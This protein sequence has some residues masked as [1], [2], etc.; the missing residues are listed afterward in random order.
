MAFELPSHVQKSIG[1]FTGRTWLLPRIRQWLEKTSDRVFLVSGKPGA[2]NSMISAWLSGK[3]PAPNEPA[4]AADLNCIRSTVSAIHFCQATSGNAPRAFAESVAKQLASTVPGFADCVV[5][6]LAERKQVNVNATVNVQRAEHSTITGIELNLQLGSLTDEPAFDGLLHEPLKALYGGGYS[7]PILVIVNALDES[8]IYTGTPKLPHLLTR[9]GEI[10]SQFRILVTTRND[11]EVLKL[12]RSVPPCDRCDL[13]DDA[14]AD[15]ADVLEYARRRLR[16]LIAIGDQARDQFA[17]RLSESA[18]GVFLYAAVVLDELLKA[19]SAKLPD[20]D[21]YP[22]PEGLSTLYHDLLTRKLG[23]DQHQWF[24]VYEPLLGLIAVGQGEG[25]TAR[26]LT[27]IVGKDVRAGL[28]DCKEYLAGKLP[29][30]P[31]RVFRKSFA[32]FLLEDKDNVDFHIDAVSMHR[33]IVE[34]Y[35]SQHPEDWSKCDDYGLSNLALHLRQAGLFDRLGQLISQEWM[36]MRVERRR[37][38]YDGFVADVMLA[39]NDAR[40][41]A[42]ADIEAGKEPRTFAECVWY[43]LIRTS[44]RSLVS[45]YEPELL[46]RAVETGLWSLD[47]AVSVATQVR[48]PRNRMRLLRAALESADAPINDTERRRIVSAALSTVRSIE[49]PEARAIGLCALAPRLSGPEKVAALAEELAAARKIQDIAPRVKALAALAP[50]LSGPEKDKALQDAWKLLL[51]PLKTKETQSAAMWISLPPGIFGL[52]QI[53]RLQAMSTLAP[54]SSGLLPS[55]AMSVAQQIEDSES[56]AMVLAALLPGLNGDTKETALREA[57]SAAKRIEDGWARARTLATLGPQLTS[58]LAIETLP[59]VHAIKDSASRAKALAALAQRVSGPDEKQLVREA[60]SAARQIEDDASQSDVLA[61]LAA[62]LTGPLALEALQV[63]RTIKDT[64]SRANALT[65]LAG[66]L[67][68]AE[69]D[70]CLRTSL[71]AVKQVEN[72]HLRARLMAALAPHLTNSLLAEALSIARASDGGAPRSQT[73]AALVPKLSDADQAVVLRE[74]LDAVRN[75]R[76]WQRIEALSALAPYLSGELLAEALRVQVIEDVQSCASSLTAIARDL[77]GPQKEAVLNNVL[78][79][80]NEADDDWQRAEILVKLASQLSGALLAEA[81]SAARA[82]V[83][84]IPRA[85]ALAA[86]AKQFSDTEKQ[87]MLNE[88]LSSAKNIDQDATRAKFLAALASQLTGDV[89]R[90]TIREAVF[91]ARTA[92]RSAFPKMPE[93]GELVAALAQLDGSLISDALSMVRQMQFGR[94]RAAALAAL[95]QQMT[96]HEREATLADEVNQLSMA[97]KADALRIP[98][99]NPPPSL[100]WTGFVSPSEITDALVG[101]APLLTRPLLAQAL[102]L[103]RSIDDE[104]N[105]TKAEAL[106]ALARQMDAP[107]KDAVIHEALSVAMKMDHGGA[108]AKALAAITPELSEPERAVVLNNALATARKSDGEESMAAALAAIAPQ[109]SGPLLAEALATALR[110]KEEQCK[111]LAVEAIAKSPQNRGELTHELRRY[112]V[113]RLSSIFM[114]AER[115]ETYE[116]CERFCHPPLVSATAVEAITTHIAEVGLHWTWP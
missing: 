77:H 39:W 15:V 82:L 23:L 33:R 69:K 8:L 106:T 68:G 71:I 45:Q 94:S 108:R 18:Q 61:T 31:F 74:A 98:R 111:A 57:L 38:R 51:A 95:M 21:T 50:R 16:G 112:L 43:A 75:I 4:A 55:D 87:A 12:F 48:L 54:Y 28:R 84:D 86:L 70:T 85:R 96:M 11:P 83:N 22:L 59:V 9:L 101:L 20:L 100:Y 72:G 107:E 44:V 32:D 25:L 78:R 37:H 52:N 49:D 3:G 46:K 109:L 92:E 99:M 114:R 64:A 76:Q 105:P 80:T 13:V 97:Q 103:V 35:W 40:S 102:S 90:S 60:F 88:A 63:A 53:E 7:K 19:A 6:S 42:L 26:Q 113:D 27:E 41:R 36:H 34:H 104:S 62:Q 24:E 93:T 14:P 115:R 66:S 47:Q 1:E 81:V 56:R 73:L 29:D 10:P 30:G 17:K 116:F 110:I 67:T 79:A 91:A 89:K 2:G 5:S 58:N 65:A